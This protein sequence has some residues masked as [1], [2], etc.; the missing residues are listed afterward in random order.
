MIKCDAMLKFFTSDLRRNLTKIFCLT[1]GLAIGLLLVAK[2]FV[3][4]SFD[5]A[6][7]EYENVYIVTESVVVSGE[8]REY[9]QTAGAIAPGLKRYVPQVDAAM[10]ITEMWDGS[11]SVRTTDGREF[12]AQ[13]I[14][15][16]DSCMF[17]VL[18][19][20]VTSGDPHVALAVKDHCMIPR[21]LAEKIG[22]DVMGKTLASPDF[23][24]D[25]RIMID[26]VYEDFPINSTFRNVIYLSLSSIGNFSA[27]GRDNWVGNDRYKSFVRL[28][29]GVSKE[30]VAPHIQRMLKENVDNADLE[31]FKYN[32]SLAP[33]TEV[34]ASQDSVKTM[35]WI[36]SLLAFIILLSASLNY[37]LIVIGQLG[38]RGKEMGVRK[39][40]G[41]SNRRIFLRILGESVFFL[42]VSIV[43]AVL[44]VLSLSDQCEML[45][46]YPASVLLSS[47]GVWI[48][49]A[50]V[51]VAL[52][53]ITGVIP[54]WI[55]CRTPVSH[56]FHQNMRRRRFW[57]LALLSVQFFATG[58]M[59]CLLL[60]VY[61]QYHMMSHGDMGY[62]YENV[63]LLETGS[64]P[65][66]E[67]K[68]LKEEL[69][70][71][72]CVEAVSSADQNFTGIMISGNNVWMEGDPN[73]DNQ[74]NVT[75]MYYANPDI[76]DVM[77]M[78]FVQGDTFRENADSTVHQVVVEEG[79]IDVMKKYFGHKGDNIVGE[80]FNITEHQG[81]DG[82]N[83]FTVC[84]VIKKL[85]RGSFYSD[86]ADTRA[87]VLFPS[88]AVCSNL[89]VR[90]INLTP[91][92]LK[93]AQNVI[94]R[95]Y[96][97]DLYILPFKAQVQAMIAP[98]KRFGF[99]VMAAG[100]A[101]LLITIIGLIGYTADEVQR[102]AK[103]IAIRKV[104]GTTVGK[105]LRIFCVD[106]LK[107]AAPSLLIGGIA[108]ILI[109]RDW[110]SQF[111]DQVSLSPWSM[112]LCL[113]VILA[114]IL[115]VVCLNALKVARSNP[116]DYLRTE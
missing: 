112:A 108:A 99:S 49:E 64:L 98:V 14:T 115:L 59:F 38:K 92:T 16:A 20:K 82:T 26:G 53:L 71:L 4:Q 63:A 33:L 37:L 50:C 85:R 34:Y 22:G 91:E 66:N 56:V 3:E 74:V 40:Y 76:F 27:D 73:Q 45:L 51:C 101:I 36:L 105:I 67:R 84:G 30:E 107:V 87:G 28:A 29:K 96:A 58:L 6:I 60:L 93:E 8:F 111:T 79:F 88:S 113:L 68:T 57:K 54:A 62:D 21:S 90:F 61:R 17:D 31:T 12:E 106:I 41:T 89:Y 95:N 48:V 55:Y 77:G 11:L 102:R 78:E 47:P 81:L 72:A 116:V 46:G 97:G 1:I 109:G 24:E 103:E 7:P 69:S 9:N 94:D 75:D 86:R 42:I 2:A 19:W 10:R 18:Q 32:I 110:L 5:H 25:Y 13:G 114:V 23:N 52:L 83:E 35:I 80:R 100:I 104:N 15:M 43:L 44:V 70:R 39:C 65:Q